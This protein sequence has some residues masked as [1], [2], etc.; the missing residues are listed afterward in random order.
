[1]KR[2]LLLPSTFTLA[3]ATSGKASAVGQS[4]H[5]PGLTIDKPFEAI[6]RRPMRAL[7]RTI[8]P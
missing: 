7:N 8:T 2:M 6:R 4:R 3:A 5:F 1:M